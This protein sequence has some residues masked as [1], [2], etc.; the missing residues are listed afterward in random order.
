MGNMVDKYLIHDV[1][2]VVSNLSMI[3]ERVEL[4]EIL[5]YTVEAG[6]KEER[7]YE[8]ED[9]MDTIRYLIVNNKLRENNGNYDVI[10]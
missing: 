5:K 2:F 6:R 3:S 4:K 7:E 9:I 10:I 8:A 1:Y